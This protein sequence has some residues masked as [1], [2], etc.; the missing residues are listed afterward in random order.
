MEQDYRGCD[1]V[2]AFTEAELEY[3]CRQRLGR[4]ATS[5]PDGQPH[6]VPVVYEFDGRYIYFGGWNLARSLKYRN[7]SKNSRVAF[8]VD[9]MASVRPWVLRG[10]ELRGTAEVLCENNARCIRITVRSKRSWGLERD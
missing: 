5:S 7:I 6:I 10:I 9:D 2:P 4:L 1:A 3:L 8:V